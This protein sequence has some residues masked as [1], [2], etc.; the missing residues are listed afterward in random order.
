MCFNARHL[1]ETMMMRAIQRGDETTTHEAR[2]LL[3][4]YGI[5]NLFQV[6]GFAHPGMVI[7]TNNAPFNP[8]PSVWGLV[9]E[10][11]KSP[12]SIWNSTLNARGE[13]VFEKPAFKKSAETKRCLIPADGFYDFHHFRGKKYPF[14]IFP[15][16]KKPIYFAGLWNDWKNS[17]TG[18]ILNTYSIVTTKANELMAKIH[19]KPKF[20]NDP[21][22]PVI[23]PEN[24]ADEWLKPLQKKELQELATFVFPD[25]QLDAHTVRKL[26]GKG[27][28][29]NVPDANK[30][31]SYDELVFD[32]E[33]GSQLR[34]FP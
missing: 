24:L 15:K 13:T 9:P 30:K 22:M 1:I 26:T 27:S 20:S 14:Y 10:W 28:P 2:L 18:E 12:E 17:D 6:S 19:N 11:A 16:N 34:L 5:D 32:D 3:K 21:R 7:Y 8:L 25:S 33:K 29:G 31:H 4:N 23:L